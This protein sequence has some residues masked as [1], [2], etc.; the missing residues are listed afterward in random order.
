MESHKI[1]KLL[2]SPRVWPVLLLL[3]IVA[4][5]PMLAPHDPMELRPELRLLPPGPGGLFGTDTYG[6]DIF[7]R[8]LCAARVDFFLALAASTISV[9]IGM[10]LG[11]FG[12]YVGGAFDGALQRLVE[13]VQSFPIMLIAMA[14]LAAAGISLRNVV[15]VI[16]LIN[17]PVYIKIVRSLVLPIR[18]AQFIE[19]ARCAGNSPARIVFTQILPNCWGP[20]ISQ[21][22]INCAWAIQMIAGLSFI[23][24]GVRI[25]EAEWGL[26]IN[27]GAHYVVTGQWWVAFF[28]GMA[29]FLAVYVLNMFGEELDA[30]FTKG[31]SVL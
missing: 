6:M 19:A 1:V 17:V 26:M 24:L 4:A 20:V 21:F 13:V 27:M 8:V 31:Q 23:G 18:E 30:Q 16:A 10:P 15:I 22:S 25:P 11:A 28:P 5:G 9:A 12:G 2:R 14:I 3:A 7:S 29:I